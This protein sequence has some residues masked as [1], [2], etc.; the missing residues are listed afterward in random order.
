MRIIKP[1]FKFEEFDA[2][3]MLKR[4]E[5]AG[6]VCYKSESNITD[7]SSENFVKMIIARG[8]ESVLEHVGVTAKFIC[9]RACSHQLVRHRIA[10]F[11]QESQRYCNYTKKGYTIIVPPKINQQ[12][13]IEPGTYQMCWNPESRLYYLSGVT[14]NKIYNAS[15]F[16][17]SVCDSI[18][19][20]NGI[21]RAS[22]I[23]PEDARFVL[24]NAMKTE[25][26]ITANLREW[27][28][29]YRERVLNQH[30]QWEVQH[31]VRSVVSDLFNVIPEFFG[32]IYELPN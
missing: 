29:I 28:H 15:I 32:D 31:L 9:S 19:T 5:S 20:Y 23:N 10:S 24:P 25:V 1:S 14:N 4:I 12:S 17:S 11:S 27:R 6:R 13:M 30:A 2:K 18:D 3:K 16:I 22:D 21:L 7:D 26:V 8:H